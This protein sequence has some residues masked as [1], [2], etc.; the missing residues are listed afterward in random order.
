[1]KPTLNSARGTSEFHPTDDS[2]V[3]DT[4]VA[5]LEAQ[6][7]AKSSTTSTTAPPIGWKQLLVERVGITELKRRVWHFV[8]GLLPVVSCLYPHK[9]PI[10]VTFQWIAVGLITGLSIAIAVR[11]KTIVRRGE[12][13]KISS[14]LGYSL[15]IFGTLMLFPAHAELAMAVTVILAFGDGS[16]TLC[17]L[18]LR[19]PRLPWNVDKRWSGLVAFVTVG[20]TAA[21]LAYWGES[22]PA[23]SFAVAALCGCSA[24][25][26][27]GIVESL[28]SKINDNIRVGV[29]SA[30]V[31]ALMHH[32]TIGL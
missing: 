20:A 29:V 9:D 31:L 11:Y 25:L 2:L 7:Q 19:G 23:A 30:A 8:P 4:S 15:S 1:M 18:A 27:A 21:T 22:Q 10:S 16:A 17:G 3:S 32:L 6:P 12:T 5:V 26:V 24:A 13:T 14:I 28:P